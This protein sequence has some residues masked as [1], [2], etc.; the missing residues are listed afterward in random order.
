MMGSSLLRGVQVPWE[1]PIFTRHGGMPSPPA[2][3]AQEGGFEALDDRRGTH[4]VR[5]RNLAT[6]LWTGVP[7]QAGS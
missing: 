1:E 6:E 2:A 4:H 3:Q 7:R 5:L